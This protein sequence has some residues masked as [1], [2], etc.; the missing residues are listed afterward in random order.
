MCA[1]KICPVC[2]YQHLLLSL[3]TPSLSAPSVHHSQAAELRDWQGMSVL[4][5][6]RHTSCLGCC[7]PAWVVS[8]PCWGG[9]KGRVNW[10]TAGPSPQTALSVVPA[11]DCLGW[12]HLPAL[13][14]PL[15]RDTS[16][17]VN[18]M[19]CLCIQ[20]TDA[21]RKKWERHGKRHAGSS[22]FWKLCLALLI[23]IF[24][25]PE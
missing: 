4:Q 1:P 16:D 5:C 20:G 14:C 19:S 25:L 15:W 12:G 2:G 21:F 3:G 8:L 24:G 10:H 17:Q 23:V 18:C 13:F 7:F 6:W 9:V 11:A 22:V